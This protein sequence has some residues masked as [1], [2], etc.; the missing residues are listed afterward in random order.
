M[1][2]GALE[3]KK[4]SLKWI[5]E[6]SIRLK[7]SS[8]QSG[9]NLVKM[10]A[11]LESG[12]TAVGLLGK[13]LSEKANKGKDGDK[14]YYEENR[15]QVKGK[16]WGKLAEAAA[17]PET[18]SVDSALSA[19]VQGRPGRRTCNTSAAAHCQ[20]FEPWWVHDQ[21]MIEIVYGKI[22]EE[23]TER[24]SFLLGNERGACTPTND[25]PHRQTSL[26]SRH[27]HWS[28]CRTINHSSTV[29]QSS[30]VLA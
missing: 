25:T 27:Y 7:I 10:A 24:V 3:G 18:I 11:L 5:S 2:I 13:A 15:S 20:H 12:T 4:R 17:Q 26:Q 8:K 22:N 29:Y 28:I 21:A 30:Q 6:R 19:A 9:E 14:H 23:Y 1:R 16:R